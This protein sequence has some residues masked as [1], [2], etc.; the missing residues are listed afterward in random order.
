MAAVSHG[1]LFDPRTCNRRHAFLFCL[2]TRVVHPLSLTLH[3]YA[4]RGYRNS[5]YWFTS[6]SGA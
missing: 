4:L 3:M 2:L 1:G 5:Y 6:E